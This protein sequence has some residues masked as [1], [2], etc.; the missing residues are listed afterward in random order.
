MKNSN[1][2]VL[3]LITSCVFAHP[4]TDASFGIFRTISADN[5]SAGHFHIGFLFRGFGRIKDVAI[6]GEQT[7]EASHKGGDL[8]FGLGYAVTDNIAFNVAGSFHGDCLDYTETD[9]TR[10]SMG[11]GDTRIG[12]KFA[13]G[14]NNVKLGIN[15]FISLPIGNDRSPELENKTYLFFGDASGNEGGVFR[16]FSSGATDYGVVGLL[17]LK[18][19]LMTIDLNLGYVDRNKNDSELGWRNN[20]TIYRAALSWDLGT[21]VPFIEVSGVDF[22]GKDQF[23]TFLDDDSVFG[24][25]PVFITPGISI[26][27]GNFNIDLG[28]DIRGWEGENERAFPTALT[29][30]SNIPTGW[31]VAPAW[32]GIIGISYCGDFKRELPTVG[33]ITGV[34]RNRKTDEPLKANIALYQVNGMV[35]SDVSASDGFYAFKNLEPG[36]YKLSAST[37]DYQ[38]YDTD[39]LVKA[40]ESIPLDIALNPLDKEGTLILKIVDLK[41]QKPMTAKVSIG[42]DI[43]ETVTGKFEKILA[44]GSYRIVVIAQTEDYLP[45]EREIIINAGKTL[46]FKVALVQKESKP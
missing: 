41:N 5:G 35:A 7:G 17:S 24:P 14:S 4:N 15:P 29:D 43:T 39:L 33:N 6:L 19:K 3:L 10:A 16:Y 36:L 25:N 20:Y 21:V 13:L 45:Y 38:S 8:F 28:I 22:C 12:L 1:L 9:Y 32:A 42:D 44:P 30:S 34:I 26:R 2:V 23:F 31:G 27:P 18:S 40:G 11:I 37:T 46:E